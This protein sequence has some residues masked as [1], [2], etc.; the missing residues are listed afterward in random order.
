MDLLETDMD[1]M[2]RQI[3][4]EEAEYQRAEEKRKRQ[5]EIL[6]KRIQYIYEEG[7]VTYLDILSESENHW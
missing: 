7:E 3:E 4:R 2:T 6:K 5:Y 1:D